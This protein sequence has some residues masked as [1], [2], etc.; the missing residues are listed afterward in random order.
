MKYNKTLTTL[1]A[2]AG[3]LAG[4]GTASA[5]TLINTY[6]SA[7]TSNITATASS[8]STNTSVNGPDR[9][10]IES[11]NGFVPATG[12]HAAGTQQS[13]R[14]APGDAAGLANQWIQWDLG[15][16]FTLDSIK[17]WNYNDSSRYAAGIRQVDIYIS[18]TATPGDPEIAGAGNGDNWT[19]WA[20]NAILSAGPGAA[21]YTGFDLATVA[22]TETFALNTVSTR[23][24]RFEVDSTFRSDAIN[25]GGGTGDATDVAALAQIEFYAVPE[26]SSFALIA[27]MFGLTWVMLRRRA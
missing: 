20:G 23:Y 3:L 4:A 10:V 16:S 2:A 9:T 14:S 11:N 19:L 18:N 12:L 21:G 22:S 7:T 8:I 25:L 17:V 13:W 6:P 5:Q 26:P 24:V 27:G 15:A 1:A